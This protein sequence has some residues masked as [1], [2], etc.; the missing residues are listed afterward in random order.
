MIDQKWLRYDF[1]FLISIVLSSIIFCFVGDTD[2]FGFLVGCSTSKKSR[3]WLEASIRLLI[4]TIFGEIRI[5]GGCM[6]IIMRRWWCF[7][8]QVCPSSRVLLLLINS[9]VVN[10]FDQEQRR[11]L[12]R[13]VTSCSRPP[14]LYVLCCVSVFSRFSVQFSPPFVR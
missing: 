2:G 1:F 8:M 5:M 14:L 12:L 7:G 6:M 10:S 13:F 9:Q 11:P 4:S 3:S